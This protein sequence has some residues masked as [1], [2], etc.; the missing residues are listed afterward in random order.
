MPLGEYT[1][2]RVDAEA[3]L[4]SDIREL[5]QRMLDISDLAALAPLAE[6][7]LRRKV[8]QMKTDWQPIDQVNL[9]MA[10]PTKLTIRQLAEKAC[11]SLSQFERRFAQQSGVTPKYFTRITR[12]CHAYSLRETHPGLSWL[13][14]A[15]EAGYEDYQHLVRDFKAFAGELPQAL[16]EA[17]ARSPERILSGA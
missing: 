16:L 1:D 7:Y 13:S 3:I 9:I 14:V 15:L 6:I 12:F 5:Y 2:S 10:T 4:R 8:G 11:L 17:Q